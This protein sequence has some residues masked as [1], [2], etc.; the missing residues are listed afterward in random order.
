MRGDLFKPDIKFDLDFPPESAPKKDFYTAQRL[1]LLL[2]NENELNKQVAFLVVFNSFVTS[3]IAGS[4]LN[5]NT[6]VDI[7]VNS[8]SGFLSGQINK[9]LN[10]FLANKLK[11]EGLN[12]NFS[13][14][15]YN[16]NPFG[17]TNTQS[18]YD[19]TDLNLAIAKTLSNNRIII[20]FEGTADVPFQTSAQLKTDLLKNFTTEFLINES[21]TVRATIFYKENIDL[22]TGSTSTG[23]TKS[24]RFGTSLSFRKDFNHIGELFRRKQKPQPAKDTAE[25]K[26]GN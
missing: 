2:E 3:D 5:L 26:E 16:P 22:L 15:L 21:G 23:T 18:G 24:R 13:G 9:L 12:I 7:V 6:G 14:S 17:E 8:I 20:T 10:N 1:K 4:S 25:K 11:I 19:R